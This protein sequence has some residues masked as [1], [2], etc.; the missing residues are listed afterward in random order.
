MNQQSKRD[1]WANIS[2]QQKKSNLSIKQFCIDNEISYQTFYYRSKKLSESEITTKIHPIIVTEPT[3][4][5]SN[6]VVLT[7]NGLRTELPANLNSKQ[8]KHWVDALQ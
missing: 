7:Y 3:Q 5:Q 4:E 8:I 1:H 6:I 2:E